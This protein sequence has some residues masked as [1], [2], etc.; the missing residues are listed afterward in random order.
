MLSLISLNVFFISSLQKKIVKSSVITRFWSANSV[1]LFV[2]TPIKA[3]IQPSRTVL[4]KTVLLGKASLGTKN[5]LKST[6]Q[7]SRWISY[8][9][10]DSLAA[11][12][13]VAVYNQEFRSKAWKRPKLTSK[14]RR[15]F[16]RRIFVSWKD[17]KTKSQLTQLTNGQK[18]ARILRKY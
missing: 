12:T 17:S 7:M 1:R 14:C 3:P 4:R 10:L 6:L 8:Q 11:L 2:E 9:Q 5:H 16:N 15:R 13:K 18:I